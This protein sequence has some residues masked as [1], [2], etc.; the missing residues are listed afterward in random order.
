MRFERRVFEQGENAMVDSLAFGIK[1]GK[2]RV[3]AKYPATAVVG[4]VLKKGPQRW[5]DVGPQ[6]VTDY[7]AV[8]EQEFVDELRRRYKVEIYK[9]ALKTVNKH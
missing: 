2:T 5:T 7:Q 1:K 3:N 8:K 4:R 6:V 9:E